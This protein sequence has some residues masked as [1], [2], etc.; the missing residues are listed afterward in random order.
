MCVQSEK[1]PNFFQKKKSANEFTMRKSAKNLSVV[2]PQLS[3]VLLRVRPPSCPSHSSCK[4]KRVLIFIS[5]LS[6]MKVN[7]FSD[8]YHGF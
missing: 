8:S 2:V 5:F 3:A 4:I 7:R 1:R 6:L